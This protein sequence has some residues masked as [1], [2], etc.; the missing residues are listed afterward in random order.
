MKAIKRFIKTIIIMVILFGLISAGVDYYRMLHGMVPVFN[1]VEYNSRKKIQTYRGLFYTAS[2]KVLT[3]TREPLEESSKLRFQFITFSLDVPSTWK[4]KKADMY[5]KVSPVKECLESSV[6]YYA[7]KDI[8][9]YTYCI[10][11]IQIEKNDK[12][13]EFISY[14]Q[15]D[16]TVINTM[17]D[18]LSFGGV[19]SDHSTYYF[20]NTDHYSS[21]DVS[22]YQCHDDF[23]TDIYIA[24]KDS[25]FQTDFCTYKDDDFKFMFE[26]LDE[27]VEPEK[28]E[29]VELLP[30]VIYEDEEY[31]YQFDYP[32]SNYVFITT[33]A[34]RGKDET[35]TPLMTALQSGMVTMEELLDKGLDITK[36]EKN[37]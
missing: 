12:S 14:L 11:K 23:V 37:A 20:T 31:R 7:D 3:S 24:P 33:P 28:V 35:K 5:L 8:K 25:A 6:L 2:R 22:I 27:S 21:D 19:L 9:I 10:D 36:V 17:I 13:E 30:E 29:G 34:V 32:K 26:I 4:E 15:K 18:Q 16:H 1:R